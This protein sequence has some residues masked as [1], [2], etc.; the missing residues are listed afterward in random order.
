MEMNMWASNLHSVDLVAS[1]YVKIYMER[2]VYVK[3]ISVLVRFWK[4]VNCSK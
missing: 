1:T 3:R 4:S 2:F